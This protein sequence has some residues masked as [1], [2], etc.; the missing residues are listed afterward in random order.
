LNRFDKF[1]RRYDV[2]NVFCSKWLIFEISTPTIKHINMKKILLLVVS[3]AA[4]GAVNAQNSSVFSAQNQLPSKKAAPSQEFSA[5]ATTTCGL[6][7][8]SYIKFKNGS[9]NYGGRT[10]MGGYLE[11]G[12]YYPLPANSSIRV[13]ALRFYATPK[14][15]SSVT[16]TAKIYTANADSTPGTLLGSGSV[17]F[18]KITPTSLEDL[19][20]IVTFSTPIDVDTNYVVTVEGASDTTFLYGTQAGNGNGEFLCLYNFQ[21]GGFESTS[22]L[23]VG[24]DFDQAIEPI[25]SYDITANFVATAT[26]A[27]TGYKVSLKNTSTNLLNSVVYNY[28]NAL[29]TAANKTYTWNFGDGSNSVNGTDTS[30]VYNTFGVY[31]ISLFDTLRTW[32]SFLYQR[33]TF[34]ADTKT[35]TITVGAGGVGVNEA[36]VKA[37]EM[38]PNPSRGA[39]NI[40]SSKGDKIRSVEVMGLLGNVVLSLSEVNAEG[41]FMLDMNGLENGAYFVKVRTAKGIQTEKIILNR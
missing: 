24:G 10:L 1:K 30:H 4:F 32:E 12:Q 17:T 7:S 20:Q 39:L 38:Y 23:G 33:G 25:I 19:A 5:V 2:W 35:I 16:A 34:C 31:T 28:Q 14:M 11:W 36:A 18:S 22:T 27:G 29:T 6:D 9:D 41:S 26:P 8:L 3:L 37:F 15:A 21:G 13:H 40:S